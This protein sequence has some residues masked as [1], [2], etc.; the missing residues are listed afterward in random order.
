MQDQY[1]F[2]HDAV[3]E[4]LV[5]GN[6]QVPATS[7]KKAMTRLVRKSLDTNRNGFETQFHVSLAT[8]VVACMTQ[9]N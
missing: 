5:C 1:T 6:T 7:I 3:L 2:I 8:W 9:L 4:S